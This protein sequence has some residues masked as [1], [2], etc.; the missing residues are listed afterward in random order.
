MVFVDRSMTGVLRIP[1]VGP[2]KQQPLFM[3]VP[4]FTDQYGVAAFGS[5]ASNAYSVFPSVATNTTS[6]VPTPGI[7]K[8]VTIRGDA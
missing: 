3:G 2:R 4:T 8:F 5:S 7:F 6:F 1:I